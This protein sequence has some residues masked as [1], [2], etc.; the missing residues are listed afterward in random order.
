M[1][2]LDLKGKGDKSM[3]LKQNIPEYVYDMVLQ[4]LSNM[5]KAILL[6]H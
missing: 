2:Y 3:V 6:E 5:V 4:H 1:P